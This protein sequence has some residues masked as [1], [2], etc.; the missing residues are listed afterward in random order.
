MGSS[1]LENLYKKTY[2][3]WPTAVKTFKKH[4]NTQTR[5]H[6]KSQVLLTKFVDE[7]RGK[8][9]PINKVFDST[10]KKTLRKLEK[11]LCPL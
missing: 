7:Y 3:T 5:S 10:H 11:L 2:R 6:K 1:S 9:V 4:Q 8:E